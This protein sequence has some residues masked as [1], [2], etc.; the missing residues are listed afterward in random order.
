MHSNPSLALILSSV[1]AIAVAFIC[2]MVGALWARIRSLRVEETT[3]IMD[4]L[5]RRQETIE[6][7]MSRLER[8][9]T[10]GTA[11]ALSAVSVPISEAGS[12]V[13]SVPPQRADRGKP[14]AVGG[15]TLIVVPSLAAAV[16]EAPT[17]AVAELG[18]RF[19]AIWA[20]ADSGESPEAIARTTGQPI[21]Q[22][23]LILG[24][25]RQ[26]PLSSS[27]SPSTSSRP[28]GRA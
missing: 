4:S 24:L 18:R 7:Q 1:L 13:R 22:V 2:M 16:P 25:R 14:S 21:G 15:P 6:A 17:A 23:E 12:Q 28:G 19:G 3:R 27:P 11:G 8:E 9:R 26:L 5:A 10:Q 20:L